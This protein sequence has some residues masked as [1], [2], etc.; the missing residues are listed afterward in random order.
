MKAINGKRKVAPD[1]QRNGLLAKIH[2]AAKDLG[3]DDVTYRDLLAGRY[4]VESAADLE[5]PLLE[6]LVEYFQQLGWKAK[7]GRSRKPDARSQIDALRQKARRIAAD[8][9]NGE[10]RLRG[11]CEKICGVE[12]LQWCHDA[13]KLRRLMAALGKINLMPDAGYRMPD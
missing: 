12:D 9:E 7:K 13:G 1:P 5:V 11:L 4:G 3:F 2:I 6:D 8:M 10:K